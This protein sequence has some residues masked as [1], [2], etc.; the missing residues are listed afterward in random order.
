MYKNRHKFRALG[1]L[2]ISDEGF[3]HWTNEHGAAAL[4]QFRDNIL[5]ATS[6]PDSPATRLVELI[7]KVLES[8]WDLAVLCECRQKQAD[9]CKTTCYGTSCVVLGYSLH[10]GTQGGGTVFVQ[11]SPLNSQ[12]SLK[13]APP[14]ITPNQS[15]LAYLPGILLGVLNNARGVGHGRVNCCHILAAD[16]RFVWIP[17][18]SCYKSSSLGCH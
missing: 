15:H 17:H 11:P 8:S 2:H 16:S 12:W 13:L 10:Q 9:V 4:C 14:L 3:A 5:T 6:Y 1:D 7:C 18:P